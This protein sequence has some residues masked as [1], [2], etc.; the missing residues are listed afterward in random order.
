[1]QFVRSDTLLF[2]MA[3]NG[4]CQWMLAARLYCCKQGQHKALG[5]LQLLLLLLREWLHM[6]GPICA[7]TA[8]AAAILF[9][10]RLQ[11]QLQLQ[12]LLLLVVASLRML[13]RVRCK[14]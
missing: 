1:M 7:I 10:C 5:I 9:C 11:L 14:R 12:L 6:G 13:D 3:D 4:F 8:A 2:S